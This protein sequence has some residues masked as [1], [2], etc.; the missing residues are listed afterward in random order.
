MARHATATKVR[1]E[2]IA[3]PSR[4]DFAAMLDASFETLS[5]Q[6]GAVITGSVVA[7]ENDFAM[8]DVGLKTEGRVSLKEFSMLGT[9]GTGKVGDKVEV[10]LE[11]VEN[12]RGE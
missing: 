10:L 5:P 9:P 1:D 12:A 7:V 3:T 4:D 6:D 8:I 11:R 2:S